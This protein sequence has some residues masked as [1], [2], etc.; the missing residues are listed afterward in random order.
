MHVHTRGAL[1]F[2]RTVAE[3]K[4]MFPVLLIWAKQNYFFKEMHSVVY[5]SHSVVS[6]HHM[7]HN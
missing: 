3:G 1:E 2:L 5:K 4:D 7:Y 6:Q